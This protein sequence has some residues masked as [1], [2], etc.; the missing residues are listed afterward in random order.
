[1]GATTAG[2]FRIE[3]PHRCTP[4]SVVAKVFRPPAGR[5]D[6]RE[7]AAYASGLLTRLPHPCAAP[8]VHACL[9]NKDGTSVLLLEDLGQ[10]PDRM[11]RPMAL[12]EYRRAAEALG[13]MGARFATDP[14]RASWLA[15][16]TTVR[17]AREW[18]LPEDWRSRLSPHG[19]LFRRLTRASRHAPN[20]I[21]AFSDLAPTL[22]HQDATPRNI[23]MGTPAAG[24]RVV[25]LDWEMCGLG[26]LGQDLASL[27][28]SLWRFA[29]VEQLVARE[30]AA[31]D[32]Y[33]TGIASE[34][35]ALSA[36]RKREI[37]LAYL[38]TAAVRY[39]VEIANVARYETVDVATARFE[40]A[41]SL[42]TQ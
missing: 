2:V 41:V 7:L 42:V 4:V 32:G 17:H 8:R 38:V 23:A 25:L 14:P 13:R 20:V 29:A 36:S 18:L 33:L 16:G 21:E 31:L 40:E 28:W 24:D 6:P 3:F 30:A 9:R 5:G 12:D 39:L 10:Q 11:W 15:T 22:C 1:M 35:V 37:R 27:V 34:G 19:A 26:P